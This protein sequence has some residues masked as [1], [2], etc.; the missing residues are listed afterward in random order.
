M[1]RTTYLLLFLVCGLARAQANLD[2]LQKV[3]EQS[4]LKADF[5]AVNTILSSSSTE[6]N[7]SKKQELIYTAVNR[8]KILGFEYLYGQFLL[9]K[10]F[11][12]NYHGNFGLALKYAEE[13]LKILSKYNSIETSA[14][15]NTMSG[16]FN[17]QGDSKTALDY[18]KKAFKITS[19]FKDHEKY[20]NCM[21]DHHLMIGNIYIS[22]EAYD[23]AEKHLLK[24]L[25]I[26]HTLDRKTSIIYARLN[27]AK[28]YSRKEDFDTALDILTSALEVSKKENAYNLEAVTELFIARTYDKMG[29][30]NAALIN[31]KNAEALAEQQKLFDRL[32]DIYEAISE[33]YQRLEDTEASYVYHLKYLELADVQRKKE[34]EQQL[35]LLQTELRFK[36]TESQLATLALEKTH[37]E[38]RNQLLSIIL[39]IGGAGILLLIFIILLVVNRSKLN[40]KI[41]HEKKEKELSILQMTALKSQMNPHFIFNALNSIQE[42]ILKEDTESAYT[43]IS[44]FASLVRQILTHSSLTFVPIEEEIACIKLYLELER[45]RF[46]DGLTI[47]FNAPDFDEIQIPPLLIQPYIENALKHGLLHKDGEKKLLITLSL[48]ENHI[49]VR[50]EDNG[51]GRTAAAEIQARR[52]KNH[53]SFATQS[54]QNRLALLQK[55]YSNRVGVQYTDRLEKGKSLG[56]IVELILPIEKTF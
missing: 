54:I 13:A 49:K 15:Y 17:Y 1:L 10:S 12:Q 5:E 51:I 29:K 37:E 34:K 18:M 22:M 33:I 8:T 52:S 24:A 27:L 50:V 7:T 41:Q 30:I 28:I 32:L 39:L 56:T 44:K 19:Y 26:S 3:L 38:D 40:A 53:Q 11:I 47:T 25:S 16:I 35:Q 42:L 55:Q 2:S 20:D 6:F 9:K 14:C 43:Y 36:E 48:A 46:K 45:L 23:L 4:T 21:C 31:Y